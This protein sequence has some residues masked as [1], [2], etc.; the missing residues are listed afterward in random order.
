MCAGWH[1][2]RASVRVATLPTMT[3]HVGEVDWESLEGPYGSASAVPGLLRMLRS[4]DAAERVEAETQLKNHVQHQGMVYPPAGAA[5]PYLIDLLSD[6]RAPDRMVGFRLV[7]TILECVELFEVIRPGVSEPTLRELWLRR[8]DFWL[9]EV[10]GQIK[11]H[12]V[13]YRVDEL[14]D[15]SKPFNIN[16]RGRAYLAVR[17]GIPTYLRLLQQGDDRELRCGLAYLLAHYPQDWREMAPILA[18][19]LFVESD[20]SVAAALCVTAGIAGEPTDDDMVDALSRWRGNP[21][22]AVRTAALIGLLAV[23]RLPDTALL[24]ELVDCLLDIP[25]P[26]WPYYGGAPGYTALM[27]LDGVTVSAVPHLADLI[28]E[29]LRRPGQRIDVV[30]LRR[31]F[32]LTF[33]HGPLPRDSTFAGL[34]ALQQQVV[35]LL[36]DSKLLARLADFDLVAFRRAVGECNLPFTH[37]A[38]TAWHAGEVSLAA[39]MTTAKSQL[40]KW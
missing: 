16:P 20:P 32:D 12:D 30:L 24:T 27:A 21:D 25:Y 22:Q 23:L 37:D 34:T 4:G 40:P 1:A 31:L 35:S 14:V 26:E 2:T 17:A 5:V 3:G 10:L 19:Q 39:A 36:V 13:N 33:P 28:V 9:Y 38:L 11:R 15:G 7:A 18:R 6:G 29:R 8:S